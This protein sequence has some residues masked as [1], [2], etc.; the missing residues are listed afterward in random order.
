MEE[1]DTYAE[2]IAKWG[3]KTDPFSGSYPYAEGFWAGPKDTRDFLQYLLKGISG[4]SQVLNI[5][6]EGEYGAGK[7]YTLRTLQ[8]YI[9]SELKGIALYAYIPAKASLKGFRDIYEQ[10]IKELYSSGLVE[11][12]KN[13]LNTHVEDSKEKPSVFDSIILQEDLRGALTNLADENQVSETIT[14][15]YGQASYWQ[16]QTLGFRSSPKEETTAVKILTEIMNLY[17]YKFPIIVCLLDELEN[18]VGE[19]STIRSMRDG[20]RNFYDSLLYEERSGSIAIVSSITA[21]LYNEVRRSLGTPVLDRVD[22]EKTIE[23]LNV[24][25]GEEFVKKIFEYSGNNN[26]NLCPPFANNEAVKTFLDAIK[27]G[28]VPGSG[29]AGNITPRRITKVGKQIFFRACF[30]KRAEIDSAFIKKTLRLGD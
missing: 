1:T 16:Q 4:R 10:L 8:N 3:F 11:I 25:E 22:F 21:T 18:V 20:I 13:A 28:V 6:L 19:S 26:G 15:L 23:P 14:W 7:T 17:A 5:L 12:C 9:Q 27:V 24:K 29:K 30:E 2:C